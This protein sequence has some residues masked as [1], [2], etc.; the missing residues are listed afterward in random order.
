MEATNEYRSL[1]EVLAEDHEVGEGFKIDNADQ[2]QWAARK[3]EL[4]QREIDDIVAQAN[5]EIERINAWKVEAMTGARHT[6]EF[7]TPLLTDYHRK[8]IAATPEGAKPKATI[9]LVGA[10]LTSRAKAGGLNYTN[11]EAFIAW[12][13]ENLPEA[14]KTTKAIVKAEAKA[15]L[16]I[17]KGK[18]TAPNGSTAE[19]VEVEPDTRSFSVSIG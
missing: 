6:L 17:I 2:A 14:V 13:E 4:A 16:V 15:R 19:G 11:E 10:K 18:A 1:A 5:R 12:A 3:L 9:P 8:V 7:F